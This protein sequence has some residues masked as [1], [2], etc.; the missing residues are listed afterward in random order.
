MIEN[1][2]WP[3]K[4]E[5]PPK[6]DVNPAAMFGKILFKDP[7][8]GIEEKKVSL[9]QVDTK[10]KGTVVQFIN[11]ENYPDG[12]TLYLSVLTPLNLALY[13]Q[14]QDP[15]S[16]YISLPFQSEGISNTTLE[17]FVVHGWP[18][19]NA[20]ITTPPAESRIISGVDSGI[21]IQAAQA[22][23]NSMDQGS[24]N[25]FHMY[26]DDFVDMGQGQQF[27]SIGTWFVLRYRMTPDLFSSL[28]DLAH[29]I[30]SLY[31]TGTVATEIVFNIPI[32]RRMDDSG[33]TVGASKF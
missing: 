23:M 22:T 8:Y 12:D 28:S 20:D 32:D 18:D 25:L 15:P 30:F 1:L 6:L 24:G 9:F 4:L 33:F 7:V 11:I 5:M 31:G 3:K 13:P 27:V 14:N 2:L 26:G 19:P 21:I 17:G 10:D 16:G 29:N